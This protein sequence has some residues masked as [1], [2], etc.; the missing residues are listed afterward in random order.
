MNI[1]QAA[2]Q[3]ERPPKTIR[4]YEEIGLVTPTRR[5]DNRYRDYSKREIHVLRFVA[6]ARGLGF[7]VEECRSLVA[8]YGDTTRKS[9]DVKEIALRRVADIDLKQEELRSMRATLSELA[10]KCHGDDRPDCPI[11][12]EFADGPENAHD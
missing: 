2:A 8:L 12:N 11:L 6:R 5:R 4:Y 10:N 3:A 7:P 1:S 9:A